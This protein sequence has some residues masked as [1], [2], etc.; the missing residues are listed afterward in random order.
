M[1]AGAKLDVRN[2][3]V[4]VRVAQI[5]PMADPQRH[6]V[7]VKLDVPPGAPAAPGMYAEVMIPDINAPARTVLVIPSSAIIQRGSLPMVEVAREGGAKE[8]RIVRKGEYLDRN[9]V[10]ILSGLKD[11]DYVYLQQG[12]RMRNPAPP[13]ATQRGTGR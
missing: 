9:H 2:T 4:N 1:I 7:T 3:P 11:S 5:F 10:T 12:Q 6:T 8:L 13:P